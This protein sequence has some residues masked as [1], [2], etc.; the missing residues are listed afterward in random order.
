MA[1]SG[2]TILLVIVLSI[3]G[4]LVLFGVLQYITDFRREL[5]YINNEIRR[6]HGKEKR[7]WEKRK[8][9]LWLSLIPFVK[10]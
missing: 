1:I 7:Y 2:T 6:N 10:Y 8:K 9:K 4:I 3:V 5:R